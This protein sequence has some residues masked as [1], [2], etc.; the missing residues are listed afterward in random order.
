[1]EFREDE[2]SKT[3]QKNGD[4]VGKLVQI[5][6]A[7]L[8]NLLATGTGA[9]YGIMNVVSSKLDP[10]KCNPT[11]DDSKQCDFTISSTEKSLIATFSIV[12]MY[13]TVFFSVPLVVRF[14]KRISLM[15]DCTLSLMGF[16][17]IAFAMNVE[18]LYISKF[19]LGYVSLTCRS[20]IQPFICEISNPVV[21]GVTTSLYVLFYISGQAFSVLIA[22][23]WDDGWRYVSAAFGGLMI[24]CFL[25]L[26]LW[27]HESP[28]WLLEKKYFKKA[29]SALQFYRID[30][31]ILIADERKRKTRD[32]QEKSYVE[33][34]SI[35]E[36]ESKR[37]MNQNNPNATNWQSKAKE[38]ALN[39]VNTF[40]RPD[41][42][43]PFL[44][45]TLMLGLV[46]LSGFVVMANYSIKLIE[47]YGY[48]T[49]TFVDA[50]NFTVI[51]YL[52]RIPSSFLALGVL[53]RFKKRHIYLA[54]STILLLV[55]SGLVAFTWLV[56]SGSITKQAFVGSIG[57][58]IIPLLLFILFYATFSFGY[59]NIPFSLMGE[60]FPPN[61]SS[62]SNTFAFIFSNIFG[63]IAVQTALLINDTHGLQ[64]VFFIPVGAIVLSILLAGFFMPETH[65][66][67][68]EEIRKIYIK[69]GDE[70]PVIEEEKDVP[71]YMSL[72]GQL[73]AELMRAIKQ[74]NS[75]Y[76][77]PY[78]SISLIE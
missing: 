11:I 67:S 24:I 37:L 59:G 53:Q 38:N 12:G 33:I 3:I 44:L 74:R 76:P 4:S 77:W 47:E 57:Y 35:Y 69:E 20:A 23:Q 29:T 31:E 65:G 22:N 50:S 30:R 40:K 15:I 9:S 61:A 71:Y 73:N 42:Y 14:G 7:I 1:M 52:S 43:K 49:E 5:M 27:I 58:Q 56:A 46:D 19:L 78:S 66:L 62:I 41:V 72:R 32:G 39:V 28:D 34:V 68:M 2:A 36:E 25:S 26:L 75:V 45:L 10:K 17:L 64:Y 8:L 70:E 51:V 18:M 21:R 13:C 55:I 16:L 60:L 6:T 63:L 54:V 48:G